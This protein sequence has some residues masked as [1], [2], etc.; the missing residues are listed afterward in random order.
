M[1]LDLFDF[2]DRCMEDYDLRKAS[3]E[4]AEKVIYD[5]FRK[6]LKENTQNLISKRSLFGV[7]REELTKSWGIALVIVVFI[8]TFFRVA[9]VDG[10]SMEPT[11]YA[12]DLVLVSRMSPIHRNDVVIVRHDHVYVVKRAIV[13]PGDDM[14]GG[15]RYQSPGCV[16]PG[17]LP[18]SMIHGTVKIRCIPS[19]MAGHILLCQGH[20]RIHISASTVHSQ[21]CAFD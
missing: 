20:K 8:T 16:F 4:Y 19:G 11:L 5:H 14:P 13:I 18:S 12:G 15:R 6:L 9:I 10:E 2:I 7:S 1:K 17:F 3:F 21:S